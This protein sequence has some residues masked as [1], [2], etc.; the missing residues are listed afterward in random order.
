MKTWKPT[1]AGI[2]IIVAVVAVP[3][4]PLTGI[5][6]EFVPSIIKPLVPVPESPAP[7]QEPEPEP[8]PRVNEETPPPVIEIPPAQQI[9]PTWIYAIIGIGIALIALA[10]IAVV[11][12]VMA[13]RRRKWGLALTGGI[14]GLLAFPIGT[15]LGIT[16]IV[17]LVKSKSEFT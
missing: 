16:A 6:P 12:G 11:G 15:A 3:F 14:L 7:A 5:I 17:L 2:L 10:V 13:L 4:L 8:T 1:V 9:T